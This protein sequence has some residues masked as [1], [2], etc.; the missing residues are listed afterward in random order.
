M[1]APVP[2]FCCAAFPW[3]MTHSQL[4]LDNWRAQDLC[5]HIERL[6]PRMRCSQ[7]AHIL[8]LGIQLLGIILT[9]SVCYHVQSSNSAEFPEKF[10]ATRGVSCVSTLI[11]P[12]ISDCILCMRA[13]PGNTNGVSGHI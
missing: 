13:V 5:C 8:I 1:L 6:C 2:C 12:P 10:T 9:L 4:A 7:I 11:A 3:S